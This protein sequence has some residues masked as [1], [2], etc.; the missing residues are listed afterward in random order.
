M[1]SNCAY[2]Q[3]FCNCDATDG[4][5]ARIKSAIAYTRPKH[6]WEQP[7]T[8]GLEFD[9][10]VYQEGYTLRKTGLYSDRKGLQHEQPLIMYHI[11]N[12]HQKSYISLPF[13]RAGGLG[14]K[15]RA[16]PSLRLEFENSDPNRRRE[17]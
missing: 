13:S 3:R 7:R 2:A 4:R 6:R 16:A 15:A 5:M 9:G 8:A 14:Y 17:G 12:M 10:V 1:A 11:G